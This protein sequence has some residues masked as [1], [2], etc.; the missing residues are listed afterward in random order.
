MKIGYPCINRTIGC[1]ADKTFRLKSYSESR[2]VETVENNLSCLLQILKFNVEND[3]LFFRITSDLVPFASHP[4]NR[5]DWVS[6]FAARFQQIGSYIRANNMRISMHPDQFNV[7]NSPDENVFER[8]V[9]EL[10]YHAQVLDTMNL[11]EDAKIQLHA[12]GVY[13]D[14][15]R[16]MDRFV[17]RVE[18]LPK[19]V[20]RRLV[21][22]NDDRL[23][24]LQDCVSLSSG[25]GIPVIFDTFH[26]QLNGSGEGLQEAMALVGPTWK[27]VDGIPMVDYSSQSPGQRRGHHAESL[28]SI[29]FQQFLHQTSPH[30]FDVMLEIKDKEQSALKATET[31]TSDN[32]FYRLP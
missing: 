20:R 24:T 21:I 4:I 7:L 12:G 26:H 9:A 2:L 11:E 8:T 30:D 6:R 18:Q 1:T 25:V 17:S 32:R 19:A 3:I 31:L 29:D 16:S 13:G 10:S 5:V 28:D 22:E 15:A 14:R 27:P 23:Y